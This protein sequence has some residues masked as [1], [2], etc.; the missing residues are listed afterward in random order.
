MWQSILVA[1]TFL[2]IQKTRRRKIVRMPGDGNCQFHSLAY[3]DLDHVEVRKNVVR[4]IEADWERFLPFVDEH[5]SPMYVNQMSKNATWGD[6][7]T[8]RAFSEVYDTTV[9]V[10]DA[11]S[12]RMISSYGSSPRVKA[13]SYDGVH[14]NSLVP[15][16]NSLDTLY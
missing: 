16:W 7:L 12:G 10:F 11:R 2:M 3:P 6:E 15:Q 1:L 5:E 14:Y 13:L 4:H 8:L 9:K